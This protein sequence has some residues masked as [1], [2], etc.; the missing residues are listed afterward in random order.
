MLALSWLYR[1]EALSPIFFRW[2]PRT[3]SQH[4]THFRI[5]HLWPGLKQ[6]NTFCVVQWF[7]MHSAPTVATHSLPTQSGSTGTHKEG[8]FFLITELY[9]SV[10][11]QDETKRFLRKIVW[12]LPCV[13]NS[14]IPSNLFQ[15]YNWRVTSMNVKLFGDSW[16]HLHYWQG[17]SLWCGF[18]YTMCKATS[19]SKR[20]WSLCSPELAVL[21]FFL[22]S[23][24]AVHRS[25]FLPTSLPALCFLSELSEVFSE[26]GPLNYHFSEA[27][28][29]GLLYY[30]LS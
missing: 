16:V 5:L 20:P 28:L 22:R 13:K 29:Y 1:K 6:Q 23:V 11:L 8:E 14:G 10:G 27:S 3:F 17:T 4:H 7:W 12:E 18:D 19:L 21:T 24:V 25:T 30:K 9:S 15:Y 26:W 2:M